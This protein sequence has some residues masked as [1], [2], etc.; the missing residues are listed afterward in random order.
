MPKYLMIA[1]FG[2]LLCATA[3]GQQLYER[4]K[5]E[6]SLLFGLS[7]VS[8]HS[9]ATPV[10]GED[11]LRLVTLDFASGY[12]AGV[13]VTENFGRSFGAELEYTLANQPFG[14][15]NLHPN[16]PRLDLD[17]RVHSLTYD[18]LYYPLPPTRRWHPYGAVGI[19]VALYQLDGNSREAAEAD[20]FALEDRWKLAANFGGGVKYM[21]TPKVGVRVDL[22]NQMTGVPGYG[23]PQSSPTFQGN[24]GAG[25]K[26]EGVLH[27][28]QFSTGL[29]FA[30]DGF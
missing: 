24:Q 25:F 8:D 9:S 13:R 14:F 11:T 21:L 2:T 3:H 10:D 6:F 12:I 20:G 26:T 17:H 29:L 22:R 1:L 15:I 30:W 18:F 23:L 4:N 19:G 27:N 28:L 7:R 16:V 5:W